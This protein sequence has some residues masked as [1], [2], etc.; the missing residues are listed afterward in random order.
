MHEYT[1][2]P[3]GAVEHTRTSV[4]GVYVENAVAPKLTFTGISAV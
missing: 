3:D 2:R 1:C 4:D